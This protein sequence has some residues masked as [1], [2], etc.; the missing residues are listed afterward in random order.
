MMFN[1]LI[2]YLESDI[3]TKVDRAAMS[4][5]LETRVPFL[6]QRVVEF[7]LSL[8]LEFK[9]R[10]GVSKWIL[11]EVLYKNVPKNLLDQPK[12]G[13]GIPIGHWLRGGLRDWADNLL[14]EES[15]KK[16]GFLKS[17]NVRKKFELHI[18][19][20]QDNEHQLWDVLMFQLWYFN[21]N[22]SI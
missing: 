18:K 14:S 17:Q 16:S 20:K 6:D 15:L 8:P 1:D 22:K 5:S 2:N 7:A 3:L 19:G 4:N 13:F 10:N 9:I 11:K 12:T 21:H